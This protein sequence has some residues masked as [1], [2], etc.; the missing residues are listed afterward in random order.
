MV[1]VK[2]EVSTSGL[3]KVAWEGHIGFTVKAKDTDQNLEVHNRFREFCKENC[4][5]NYTLGLKQLLEIVSLFELIME[6]TDEVELLKVQIQDKKE[7]KDEVKN[8]AF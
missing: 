6:L 7:D 5:G 4:E 3:R 8:N 1:E 2:T